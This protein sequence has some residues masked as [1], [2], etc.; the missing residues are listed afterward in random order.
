MRPGIGAVVGRVVAVIAGLLLV[1]LAMRLVMAM[2][3]PILPPGF[4]QA[5]TGG[6]DLLFGMVGPALPAIMAAIILA[7]GVWVFIGRRR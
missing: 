5:V 1:G 6:W 7:A 3:S 4:M 2:L